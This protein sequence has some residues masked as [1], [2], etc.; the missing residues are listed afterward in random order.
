MYAA[1]GVSSSRQVGL[2]EPGLRVCMCV[3]VLTMV[4]GAGCLPVAPAP[5]LWSPPPSP[6]PPSSAPSTSRQPRPDGIAISQSPHAAHTHD[7]ALPRASPTCLRPNL[8]HAAGPP[9]A[10]SVSISETTKQ[11]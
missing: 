5:S 6:P 10:S 8:P 3:Q 1:V 7:C 9:P 4:S 2:P 11:S